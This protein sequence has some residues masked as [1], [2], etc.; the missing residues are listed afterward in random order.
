MNFVGQ[1]KL[2]DRSNTKQLQQQSSS[3]IDE[4]LTVSRSNMLTS[5]YKDILLPKFQFLNNLPYIGHKCSRKCVLLVEENFHPTKIHINPFL[6]PFECKWSIVDGGK[7]R[8]YRAPCRRTF[9]SLDEIEKYLYRTESKL[10]IKYFVNDLIT[11]FIP[12]I[13]EKYDK[14]FIIMDDLSCGQENVQISVYND[15]NADKPDNFTYITQIRPFNNRIY[16]AFNDTNATS[17]CTCTDK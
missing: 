10:S 11:R 17:C 2:R 13:I 16:A 7:P 5:Y 12:T 6:L 4:T 14:K 8:G 3:S 15:L 9:Y 1:K